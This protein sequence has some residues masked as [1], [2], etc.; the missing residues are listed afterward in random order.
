MIKSFVEDEKHVR[1]R[2][3][4]AQTEIGIM[5]LGIDPW[6]DPCLYAAVLSIRVEWLLFGEEPMKEK[7]ESKD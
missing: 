6:T 7:H 3:K 1:Q 2:A 5:A 4:Q